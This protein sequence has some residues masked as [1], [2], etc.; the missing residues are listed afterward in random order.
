MDIDQQVDFIKRRIATCLNILI[1]FYAIPTSRSFLSMKTNC[2][3]PKLDTPWKEARRLHPG[4]QRLHLEHPRW[5]RICGTPHHLTETKRAKAKRLAR[6]VGS[7]GR[8]HYDDKTL[9][10]VNEEM[11]NQEM[12]ASIIGFIR[13][14]ALG[15][16]ILSHSMRV[17]EAVQRLKEENDFN[18]NQLGWLER[19]GEQLKRE[20]VIDQESFDREPFKQVDSSRSTRSLVKNCRLMQRL[21]TEVYSA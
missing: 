16:P 14:Q 11:T 21:H 6:S 12:A 17:E 4:I 3:P 13:Q 5:Q 2:D 15:T 7:S 20:L 1:A 9:K 19:I 10:R 8:K 18:K